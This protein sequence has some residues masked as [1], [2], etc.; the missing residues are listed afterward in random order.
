MGFPTQKQKLDYLFK[1]IGFSAAKTGVAIDETDTDFNSDTKKDGSN[2]SI[3][4]PLVVPAS[5][6]W[7]DSGSIP[8]SPPGSDS[9]YVEGYRTANAYR[10]TYDNTVSNER[11][12]IAR[13]TAGS[14]SASIEGDWIDTQF[15]ADYIV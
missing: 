8:A 13:S 12:F 2:E 7:A 4:S 10:M 11:A 14:Q 6:I 3:P 15:G 5:S 1:K 9:A